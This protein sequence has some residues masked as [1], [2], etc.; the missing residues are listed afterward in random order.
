MGALLRF[1]FIGCGIPLAFAALA[2]LLAV[3]YPLRIR[4]A[5]DCI[6]TV[7][8]NA[9]I[10]GLLTIFAALGAGWLWRVSLAL[11]FPVILVPLAL[12]LTLALLFGLFFGWVIISEVIGKI[13]L[14]RFGVYAPPMVSVIVGATLL[15]VMVAIGGFI[16][17]LGAL[18]AMISLLLSCAGLGAV[19]LTRAG[20][21]SYPA[22][23]V[24][25]IEML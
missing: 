10:L 4:R 15:G 22:K 7:P 16:P 12:I 25:R 17:F 6:S 8:V 20:T 11:V 5:T 21:R 24:R 19:I 2:G 14:A 13:V 23:T 18:V 1:A 9:G 3:M